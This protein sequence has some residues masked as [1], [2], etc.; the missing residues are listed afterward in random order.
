MLETHQPSRVHLR[1]R[2]AVEESH[3]LLCI[4]DSIVSI[5]SCLGVTKPDCAH[6]VLAE[7]AEPPLLVVP[8]PEKSREVDHVS[9]INSVLE[10]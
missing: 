3:T 7:V 8:Y 2:I 10:A 6:V 5:L 4:T 9:E 1:G